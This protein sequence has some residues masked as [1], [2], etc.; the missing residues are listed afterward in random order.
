MPT[1]A[2][3]GRRVPRYRR[4]AGAPEIVKRR[5]AS[6]KQCRELPDVISDVRAVRIRSDC[7]FGGFPAL[8]FLLIRSRRKADRRISTIPRLVALVDSAPP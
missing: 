3:Y 7:S 5:N 6:E 2:G 1:F 4:S 8:A